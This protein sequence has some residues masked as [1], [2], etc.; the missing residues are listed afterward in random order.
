MGSLASLPS[1]LL[2]SFLVRKVS[3]TLRMRSMWSYFCCLVPKSC[4]TLCNPV[5]CSPPGSSVYGISQARILEWAAIFLSRE[6][7]QL[8]DGTCVSCISRQIL[9]HWATREAQFVVYYLS[10]GQGPAFSLD[11]PAIRTWNLEFGHDIL[12]FLSTRNDPELLT[13]RELIFLLLQSQSKC[14][15][16]LATGE[17]ELVHSMGECYILCYPTWHADQVQNHRFRWG[18]ALRSQV[19]SLTIYRWGLRRIVWGLT[20]AH[21]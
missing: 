2:R 3:L 7:S 20:A 18:E 15:L 6:S 16:F 21:S 10:S 14:V 12:E 9:Y 5:G 13:Q 1:G 11:C 4:L 17:K 19:I 8:R